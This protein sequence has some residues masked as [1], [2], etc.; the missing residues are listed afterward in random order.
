MRTSESTAKIVMEKN[1]QRNTVNRREEILKSLTKNG[2][3]YVQELSE[4]YGVSEVTIRN[5][6]DKLEKKD[7]LIKARGGAIKVDF[8]V[9]TDHRLSEKYHMNVSQKERI[10]KSSIQLIENYDTIVIDSGSTTA[11]I[12]KNLAQFKDLTVITNAIN[13]TN[14]LA[15]FPNVNLI[16]PGGYFRK[17]SS[18][19]IGPLA[20]EN[21]RRFHVDKLFLGVDGFDTRIGLFTPNLEEGHL[22]QQMIEIA[23]E[24]IVVTD[25]SKFKKKSLAFICGLNKIN[26]VVTDDLIENDDRKRLEDAGIEV[27]VV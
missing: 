14:I 22:N 11:E 9:R 12:A 1:K 5:D 20:E 3:V 15:G 18:S 26:K 25:A 13:V 17:N 7:L 8:H 23:N 24:V 27:I 4:K 19:L 16:V 10:G 21:L 6:L 2:K